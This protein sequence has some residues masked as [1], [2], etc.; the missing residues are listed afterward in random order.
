MTSVHLAVIGQDIDVQRDADGAH[1]LCRV[2]GQMVAST[3]TYLLDKLVGQVTPILLRIVRISLAVTGV[4]EEHR[5][6]H[7]NTG[8]GQR[9]R[10][11]LILVVIEFPPVLQRFVL[12][13][14]GQ[15]QPAEL[16]FRQVA[17]P[18]VFLP[19]LESQVDVL[20]QKVRAD[21]MQVGGDD[22]FFLHNAFVSNSCPSVHVD[23]EV[24][25]ATFLLFLARPSVVFQYPFQFLA[26]LSCPADVTLQCRFG[27]HGK[28]HIQVESYQPQQGYPI[29]VFFHNSF[30]NVSISRFISS[31]ASDGTFGF[32]CSTFSIVS[33]H[34]SR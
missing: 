22:F 34:F 23:D 15:N 4:E 29:S 1:H 25:G 24:T 12:D 14:V 9:V 28:E 7:R 33:R 32:Q 17:A 18:R 21:G 19:H 16:L 13:A 6:L 30:F 20:Y 10:H 8:S 11:I 2:Q 26:V 5:F 31:I 3:A 27:R